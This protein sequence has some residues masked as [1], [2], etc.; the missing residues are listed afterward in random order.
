[1]SICRK[2]AKQLHINGGNNPTPVQLQQIS[3]IIAPFVNEPLTQASLLQMQNALI[4]AGF[5]PT[6]LSLQIYFLSMNY[7][8]ELVPVPALDAEQL[9]ANEMTTELLET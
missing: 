1:M 8:A 7:L 9:A 6:Q 5:N 3:G 2:T 4:A